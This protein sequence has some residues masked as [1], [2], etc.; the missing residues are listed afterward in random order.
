[1]YKIGKICF[2]FFKIYKKFTST[3]PGALRAL[4]KRQTSQVLLLSETKAGEET[5]G[6]VM[7]AIGF[8]EKIVLGSA[9]RSG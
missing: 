4:I 7:N 5:M 9:G 3:Y 8:A 1:M 2:F 6:R